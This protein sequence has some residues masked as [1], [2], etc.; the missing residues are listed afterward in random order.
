MMILTRGLTDLATHLKRLEADNDKLNR[1]LDTYKNQH[2]NIEILKEAKK[3]LEN[4][5]K[6]SQENP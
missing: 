5:L 2:A 3:G 4:K 1:E 6:V